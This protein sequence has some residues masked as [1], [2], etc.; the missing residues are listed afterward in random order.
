MIFIAKD[1]EV[2][3]EKTEEYFQLAGS[4]SF[5]KIEKQMILVQEENAIFPNKPED[6]KRMKTFL[7]RRSG[8]PPGMENF[9]H[10]EDT[11]HWYVPPRVE[12]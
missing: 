6:V 12:Y 5:K 1:D 11:Y 4:K 3:K 10:K 2:S 8:Y 7:Y 9:T